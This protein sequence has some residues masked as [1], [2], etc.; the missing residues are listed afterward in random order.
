VTTFVA[1]CQT[2]GTKPKLGNC[3]PCSNVEPLLAAY[4][5]LWLRQSS[6]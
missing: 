6:Q 3:T 4:M 1:S 2:E 5:T